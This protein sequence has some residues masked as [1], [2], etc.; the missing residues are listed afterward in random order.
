MIPFSFR[1]ALRL[2]RLLS[3]FLVVLNGGLVFWGQGAVAQVREIA[4]TED[5]KAF[6]TKAEAYMNTF[7]VAE[8]RFLQVS[9]TGDYIEGTLALSRPD[10]LRLSYDPPSP[11]TLIANGSHLIYIDSKLE[12]VSY[13]GLDSTPLGILL[14]DKISFSDPTITITGFARSQGMVEVTMVQTKDPG[15]GSLTLAFTENPFG[16]NQWRVLDAQGVEVTVSLFNVRQNVKLDPSLFSYR[17]PD[18][19]TLGN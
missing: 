17:K 5:Q 15:L 18:P 19:R 13:I 11:L 6:L 2:A 12:Q 14:G 3:V 4:L 1:S 7:R 8:S 16:L 10:R 9:S